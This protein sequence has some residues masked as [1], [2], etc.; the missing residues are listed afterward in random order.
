M[1]ILSSGGLDPTNGLLP[2]N[3]LLEVYMNSVSTLSQGIDSQAQS[4]LTNIYFDEINFLTPIAQYFFSINYHQRM[5]F[6]DITDII[7]S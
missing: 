1:S 2:I 4:Q 6:C 7:F 5:S 3:P